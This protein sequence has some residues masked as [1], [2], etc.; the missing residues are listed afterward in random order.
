MKK[1]L[2]VIC[3]SLLL[4]ACNNKK[5]TPGTFVVTGQLKNIPDQKVFL[6]ELF[7]SEKD[8]AVLDTGEIKNG[9]FKVTAAA[10][11][12]GLYRLRMEKDSVTF[13]LVNDKSELNF[14]ADYKRLEQDGATI[15]SSGNASLKKFITT[16]QSQRNVLQAKAINLKQQETAGKTDSLFLVDKKDLDLKEAAY[17]NFI[18]QYVDTTTD[19]VVA[20]FALGYSRTI[21]PEKLEKSITSLAKRFPMHLAL[22]NLVAQYNQMIGKSKG[23]PHEGGLAPD[24]NMP[25][26][27]GKPFALSMLRG[28]YVLVDFWASWCGPCRGENPNVVKAYNAYKDKN[29]TVLG[30]SLDKDKQQWL[31]AIKEDN[32]SW[33]HISDL[34]FWSSAAVALYGIDGIPYNVLVDPEGKIVATNLRGDDLESKL[35]ELLK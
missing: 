2:F 22:N 12:E 16:I 8:P 27:D 3:S 31:N 24:I 33:R 5:I 20:L 29:F 32:L 34:K 4:F 26:T 15:N 13:I 35:K 6:E 25:D 9:Q 10:P 7:F 23:K 17:K 1:L 19:P 30:V 28:K 18:I 21:E 11:E 14:A